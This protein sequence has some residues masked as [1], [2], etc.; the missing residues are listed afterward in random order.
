PTF[1][2]GLKEVGRYLGCNWA[3]ENATGLQSLVWRAHWE[4]ARE[5]CWK[6]KLIT[7]NSEDCVALKRVVEF[8]QAIGDAAQTPPKGAANAAAPPAIAWA[9]DVAA[10]SSRREWGCVKFAVQD[11]DHVNRCAWFDY[12]REKVYLRT[13]KALKEACLHRRKRS[14][15]A[16]LPVNREVE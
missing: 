2:N 12:Q 7:Y 6:D 14:Q 1:S 16:K 13:S 4:Q 9:E 8:V 11:F 5:Q 15:R 10:P 3:E